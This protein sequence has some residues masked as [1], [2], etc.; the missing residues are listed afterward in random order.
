M[1][2][3]LLLTLNESIFFSLHLPKPA[4]SLHPV[5]IHPAI[6]HALQSLRYLMTEVH[7]QPASHMLNEIFWYLSLASSIGKR[8][9]KVFSWNMYFENIPQAVLPVKE[10]FMYS[11]LKTYYFVNHGQII[12]PIKIQF[13]YI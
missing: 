4:Y 12:N 8:M 7:L 5:L 13:L 11:G 2:R 10:C 9:G 3:F 1:T 6:L